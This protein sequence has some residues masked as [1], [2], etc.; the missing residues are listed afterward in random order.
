[1]RVGERALVVGLLLAS[2]AC[3]GESGDGAS[4]DG[5]GGTAS[6]GGGSSGGDGTGASGGA[7]AEGGG[8]LGGA[9]AAGGGPVDCDA[10]SDACASEFGALFTKSNG[11]ADGT[12]LALVQ[13]TDTQCTL[14]NNDHVVLQLSMLGQVQRLVV[15]V[16]GVAVTTTQ[17]PLVGPAFSEGWHP[18]V[19]LD[20]PMDLDAHSEDFVGVSMTEA[21]EFL[22]SYLDL[23]APVSVYAYSDGSAPSSA[24]QTH[25][26]DNY[27]DG[28]IVAQPTSA[29]PVY[30]LFRYTDQVF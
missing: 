21:E 11:R 15:A 8:G 5:T 27:P 14:F 17:A 28:A 16:D 2:T 12:L 24:H 10:K 6:V 22:C 20:Y 3:G 19:F 1:M 9:G 26:N 13:T 25:R 7:G 18:D 23:G 29:S 4:V 30:L